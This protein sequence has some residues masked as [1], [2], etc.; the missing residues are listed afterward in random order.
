ML[1]SK[2]QIKDIQQNKVTFIRNF[3][4]L[5]KVYDFNYISVVADEYVGDENGIQIY[6]RGD[7]S[8]EKVW[9]VKHLHNVDYDLFS[10]YDFLKKMFSFNEDSRSGVDLFFSFA[11]CVGPPHIDEECIFLLGLKGSTIYKDYLN[12]RDYIVEKGDLLFIPGGIRHKAIACSPR[13]IA[14]IGFFGDRKK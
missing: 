10:Y 14:S 8:F 1:L 9:G 4:T 2:K 3:T 12:C 11:T 6:S 7:H 13:I 5:N